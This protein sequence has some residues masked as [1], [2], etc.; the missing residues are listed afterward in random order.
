MLLVN[1]YSGRTYNDLSQ[2]LVLH[3]TLKDYLDINDKKYIR[4]F[5]LPMAVQEKENLKIVKENYN[6]DDDDKKSYFKCH[7]SNSAYLAIFLF[8]INPFTNNQIKLQSGKFDSPYRQVLCFQGLC[9]VFKD[10]KETCELVP[11]YYY[12]IELMKN[13]TIN[14]EN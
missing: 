3:W 13:G 12:L 14:F 11:E 2:N 8:R 4:N 9:E 6:F 1:K 7:Y 5:S 10:H